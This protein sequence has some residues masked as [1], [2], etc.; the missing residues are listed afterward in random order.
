MP[1]SNHQKGIVPLLIL[2]VIGA[3]ALFGGA[4][5]IFNGLT[6]LPQGSKP[7]QQTQNSSSTISPPTSVPKL[8]SEPAIY[9]PKQTTGANT[10]EPGFS[11]S[12]PAGWLKASPND[13]LTRLLFQSP[14]E[15]TETLESGAIAKHTSNI[16][17]RL[18]KLSQVSNLDQVVEAT[19]RGAESGGQIQYLQD[20]RSSLNNQETHLLETIMVDQGIKGHTLNYIIVK[21]NYAILVKGQTLDSVWSKQAALIKTSLDSFTL[22]GE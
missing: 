20:T 17:V 2:I 16:S 10:N 3:V 5:V 19:K 18:T 22:T 14:Q 8:A 1:I 21:G 15:D 11:L 4:Y 6:K 13:Q 9:N 7:T 12:P